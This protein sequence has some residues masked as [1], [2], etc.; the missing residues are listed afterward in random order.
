[1][2]D[3]ESVRLMYIIHGLFPVMRLAENYSHIGSI[4]ARTVSLRM[5]LAREAGLLQ[6]IMINLS[7]RGE[8][9]QK[10]RF[11]LRTME[12]QGEPRCGGS[13]SM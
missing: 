4:R 10:R 7:S 5:P 3:N 12:S 6:K 1:M 9:K 11:M 8:E 13:R 2:T